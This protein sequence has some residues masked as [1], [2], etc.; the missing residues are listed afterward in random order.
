[1]DY[2]HATLIIALAYTHNVYSNIQCIGARDSSV[3]SVCVCVVCGAAAATVRTL[4][5][6]VCC[7][8]CIGVQNY[9]AGSFDTD[10]A[11]M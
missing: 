11:Y 8:A 5:A 3:S 9:I 6:L 4:T 2:C 1:M 7:Y 10:M